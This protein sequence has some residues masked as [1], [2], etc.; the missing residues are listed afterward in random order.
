M[1]PGCKAQ[2]LLQLLAPGPRHGALS[3]GR[4]SRMPLTSLPAPDL[5][6]ANTRNL[7]R[8]NRLEQI[9]Q[10]FWKRWQSEYVMELQQRSKW[11]TR[12]RDLQQGDLVLIKDENQPPLLWRLGRV[13][14][15][16]TGSDGV[17]RVADIDT[18][19]GVIRRALN[20]IC[21]LHD[22]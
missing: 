14:K 2:A 20:R 22:S 12:A 6:E 21:L 8:F 11:K 15:L 10:H 3:T 16:H 9:R 17:P 4:M 13:V 19:R 7:D 18:V 1:G 5:T